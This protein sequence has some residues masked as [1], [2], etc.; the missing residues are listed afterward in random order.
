MKK[1]WKQ[2]VAIAF[3]GFLWPASAPATI[4]CVLP[5]TLTNGTIADATQVMANYNALVTCFTLTAS[6]GANND[7]TS[8]TGLTTPLAPT[9]GGTPVYVGGT[10]T[11]AANAQVLATVVPSNFALTN[12]LRV[13]FQ[14]G[15][16]NTNTWTLNV[17]STGVKNVFRKTQLGISAAVGGECITGHPTT[18]VWDGTEYVIDGP[19]RVVGAIVDYGGSTAPP[20]ALLTDGSAIARTGQFADLFTVIGTNFGVGNGVTTYNVPDTRGRAIAGIDTNQGGF[21]N[22][23]TNAISGITATTLGAVGGDQS[24]QAHS[25]TITDP[26]HT[27]TATTTADVVAGGAGSATG[28]NFSLTT[29]TV[30]V[31]AALTGITGTN[32]TG[33][34]ASQNMPPTLIATK[35][36]Y[37]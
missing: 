10:T 21:A 20:G 27:H 28:A 4:T 37:F 31:N 32:N 29:G 18:V 14:C 7:I 26:A 16:T 17:N 8:I 11:G 35:I 25:H 24:L 1:F 13:T 34:G 2:I 5:F 36:I 23:V 19:I 30:T 33:A 9:F 15:F 6:A 12:N 3:A 22:R